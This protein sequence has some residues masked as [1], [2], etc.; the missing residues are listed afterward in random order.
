MASSIFFKTIMNR[1]SMFQSKSMDKGIN[2]INLLAN[3]VN[4][5]SFYDAWLWLMEYQ[6]SPHLFPYRAKLPQE[7]Y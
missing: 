3:R 6:G 4:I 1:M 7:P 2:R 5:S